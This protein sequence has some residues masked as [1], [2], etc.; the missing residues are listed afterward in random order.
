MS[1]FEFL[2]GKL[3]GKVPVRLDCVPPW[4]QCSS[5][6]KV[7]EADWQSAL[8]ALSAGQLF[9]LR[10]IMSEW[11]S[12]NLVQVN[13]YLQGCTA[14]FDPSKPH[15]LAYF[16]GLGGID[17][18]VTLLCDVNVPNGATDSSPQAPFRADS[19]DT[20][21]FHL[22][23]AIDLMLRV[24]TELMVCHNELGW[25]YYDRYPGLFFRLL[26][27]ANVP[28][29]R[30]VSLMMLEHL[31]LCVGPVLEISKVPALQKLIRVGDDVVLA[32]ICRVVSL[33]IVPGVVL[34]QR[35]S[36]PHRL[37]FPETLLPLQRIQRVIDSNVLWLI[38]EKGLV[39]RLVALCE[40]TEP[41]SFRMALGSENLSNSLAGYSFPVLLPNE[42][43]AAT[44]ITTRG[45]DVN[46]LTEY[47]LG[48]PNVLQPF[49]AD[50]NGV[51]RGEG[52]RVRDY[53]SSVGANPVSPTATLP[54][55]VV[56]TLR[57]FL[58]PSLGVSAALYQDDDGASEISVETTGSGIDFSWFVGCVDAKQRWRLRDL[59]L[60]EELDDN[61]VLLCGFGPPS[62][63][64]AKESFE[65]KNRAF[66]NFLSPVM[67][68]PLTLHNRY[69][70]VGAQSEVIFVLNV[71]L[72]T[73]FVGDVWR[74]MKECKWIEVAS[75]FYDRAFQPRGDSQ[76]LSPY[77]EQWQHMQELRL[78]PRF[79]IP[80]NGAG[81][82]RRAPKQR[83]IKR[84]YA[85]E[86]YHRN[87]DGVDDNSNSSDS[88]AD[89]DD[90]R[91]EGHLLSA[92]RPG[93]DKEAYRRPNS[94][95]MNADSEEGIDEKTHH[96]EA[97]TIRKLELLRG[98][99]EFL[100]TQDRFECSML[101]QGDILS[102]AAPLALKVAKMLANR[103]EDSCVETTACHALEGYLRCFSFG[104]VSRSSPN[105]PQ[106]AIGDILMRSIL[107]HRVYNATF[108][109][110]LSD[111]LTPSKRIESVFSL[112]GELVRYHYDNLM[113]L[114]EY[115]IGNVELSHLNDP[116]VTVSSHSRQLHVGSGQVEQLI[117]L[118]P[119]DRE[120]HEPFVRVLLR[121]L[122]G[123]GCDTN[124]FMRSLLL[125]LTPGLRSKIN[126]MW[127]PV[128]EATVDA[129]ESLSSSSRIGDIVTGYAHR[130]SYITACSRRFVVVISE[131]QRMEKALGKAADAPTSTPDP[132]RA[133]ENAR[134]SSFGHI[135]H[136]TLW[137]M[138]QLLLRSPHRFSLEERPFPVF[139]DD[140]DRAI[141]MGEIDLPLV[142]PPPHLVQ[143]L[144]EKRDHYKSLS[145]LEKTLLREP[146]ELVYGMLGPLNAERI[147]GTGR[148]C[149]VTTCILVFARVA[150][151]GGAG[152]VRGVLEKL[153]PLARVGY[154]KWKKE[155]EALGRG[156]KKR[157][158]GDRWGPGRCFNDDRAASDGQCHCK[159]ED[160]RLRCS[161]F[162]L[163][164]HCKPLGA[165]ELYY[166]CYGGCFFRN[167]FR[168]LCFWVGHYGACQRYVETLFYCTEVPFAELKSVM[169]YLFRLL[170]DY[171]LPDMA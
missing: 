168:L 130:F 169:L 105:E 38:G 13:R 126:Y 154:E 89:S 9:L 25:Y 159:A 96:H 166:R 122:R 7:E 95:H 150:C 53:A 59:T 55:E 31:L 15:L 28:E 74:T 107:E 73:F 133:L 24:L 123:Y 47:G 170:P 3:G 26:E 137:D 8:D 11:R 12:G 139:F 160:G 77:L 72:S 116:A 119:L 102:Q 5:G 127:K 21:P 92:M 97:E 134:S 162:L 75:K 44:P 141:V 165:V 18:F 85:A 147:H 67:R 158:R 33:L 16:V 56:D 108:V 6:G 49:V 40:V 106:T 68:V 32:V 78:L 111:S 153:K 117:R 50:G 46:G 171:F 57:A 60:C 1:A 101:Q 29:L 151:L 98:V 27:L 87:E 2:R 88:E 125:S 71:M 82:A 104:C 120:E 34:D 114:Q 121:R 17:L 61:R 143:P 142:G 138:L 128:T 146:H 64:K 23:G 58:Q 79:L 132:T 135:A 84:G 155:R 35:E 109:P 30:L 115:V 157:R 100:N 63:K 19:Q 164:G 156:V 99:L 124:L 140:T 136:L 131:M 149:V 52:G 51:D 70:I 10:G 62:D 76:V 86:K 54:V 65:E 42:A 43:R 152:A 113:L 39:Q 45:L 163:H 4:T 22:V 80:E 93:E 83:T 36:V 161:A 103:S 145:E 81:E 14:Y 41:N 110:G 129:G 48:D 144:F 167:M 148:L 94:G 91:E 66:W 112:L 69:A 118:P 90:E 20:T 37:L